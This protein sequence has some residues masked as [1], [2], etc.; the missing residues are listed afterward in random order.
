MFLRH[1]IVSFNFSWRKKHEVA[2]NS[3]HSENNLHLLLYKQ[4]EFK[5]ARSRETSSVICIV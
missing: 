5:Y 4:V 2:K 1:I 3:L